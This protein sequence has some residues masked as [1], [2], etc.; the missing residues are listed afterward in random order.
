MKERG[1]IQGNMALEEQKGCIQGT[2]GAINFIEG[3]RMSRF[4]QDSSGLHLLSWNNY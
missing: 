1:N 2:S 4:A 3:D